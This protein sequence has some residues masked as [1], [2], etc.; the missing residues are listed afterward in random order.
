M[1]HFFPFLYF[2]R[3]ILFCPQARLKLHQKSSYSIDWDSSIGY[4]LIPDRTLIEFDL[5]IAAIALISSFIVIRK[6]FIILLR[7]NVNFFFH[8]L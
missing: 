6:S 1:T 7:I 2:G 3:K 8:N 5:T 4:I